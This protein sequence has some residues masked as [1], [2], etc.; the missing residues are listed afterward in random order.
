MV[1][2]QVTSFCSNVF[3]SFLILAGTILTIMDG[4]IAPKAEQLSVG[5][6]MSMAFNCANGPISALFS[7]LILIPWFSSTARMVGA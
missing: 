3:S 4:Q 2:D 5:L 6:F 1:N 7:A